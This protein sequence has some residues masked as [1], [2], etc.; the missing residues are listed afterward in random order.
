MGNRNPYRISI[1][2]KKG[3]L[4]WG[5]VG[6]DAGRDSTGFGPKGHDEVNQ[7]KFAG[8]FG[9]PYFVG[10]NKAYWQYNFKTSQSEYQFD[11]TKPVNNSL[12]NSGI[13]KLPQAQPA[14]IW[15]PYDESEE[16]PLV[17]NGGRNAMAGPIYYSDLY[18]DNNF[19]FPQYF[20]GKLFIYDWMRGW[21]HL[22][23]MDENENYLG[24]EP[25]MPSH[26][27]SNPMDMQFAKD[28]SLYM[29]EYGTTWYKQN[30]DARLLRITYNS[31]NRS[32][33]ISATHDKKAGAVPLEVY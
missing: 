13:K 5:E 20:D 22:V 16:F 26:K 23:T 21:V 10:D 29:L 17:G 8:F 7:A 14:F 32:P 31:G 27:F 9:W 15:Y 12:N 4:Y 19:K 18:E 30:E 28:G 1:D 25:F 3:T 6:P 11:P 24:M 33:I 2:K